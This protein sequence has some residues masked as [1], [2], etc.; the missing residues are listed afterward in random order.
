MDIMCKRAS[1]G[2]KTGKKHRSSEKKTKKHKRNMRLNTY[3]KNH[4]IGFN[5]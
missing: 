1:K 5:N 3:L 2:T 4:P